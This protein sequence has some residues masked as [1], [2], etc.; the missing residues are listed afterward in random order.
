SLEEPV[1]ERHSVIA[2]LERA[3]ARALTRYLRWTA[4]RS[5]LV[6]MDETGTP[7]DTRIADGLIVSAMTSG[8]PLIVTYWI[9]DA[10]AVALL[11]LIDSAFAELMAAV[12][13]VIDDTFAGRVAGRYIAHIE[14][15]SMML[16]LPGDSARL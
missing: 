1:P 10:L 9:A 15:R 6:C 8:R 4:S 11:P 12:T 5:R 14:G 7:V 13:C 2:A 3:A 16:A